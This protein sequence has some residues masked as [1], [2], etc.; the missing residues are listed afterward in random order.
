MVEI[1]DSHPSIMLITEVI[2][3]AQL[4]P[5]EPARLTI[6]G[7]KLYANFNPLDPELGRSGIRGVCIYVTDALQCCEVTFPDS[8]FSEHLWVKI[9]L[10][11][12]DS[13]VLGCIYRSPSSGEES[14]HQFRQLLQLVMAS[15]PSHLLLTGDF[16]LGDIDWQNHLSLAPPSHCSHSFLEVIDDHFLHQH[17][18]F[19]TRFRQG[20]TPGI[21]DLIFTNEEG[22][23][24]NLHSTPGLGKSDHI[25]LKFSLVGYSSQAPSATPKLAL[26]RGN[27]VH[28][29]ELARQVSWTVPNDSSIDTQ[30]KTFQAKLDHICQL[31][32]PY[33]RPEHRRRNIFMTRE[34]MSLKK[35]KRQLWRTYV[36]SRDTLDHARFVRARNDLRWLTRR[37][38]KE[39]EASLVRGMKNDTKPFWRYTNTRLK[40]KSQ[41]EDLVRPDGSTASTDAEK[42]QMLADFFSSVFCHDEDAADVPSLTPNYA[43]TV[44]EDVEITASAVEEKLK[45][46]RP[47]SSPGPDQLHP[48]VLTEL[49]ASL[50]TPLSNLY[51]ESLSRGQLPDDWKVGQVVPI[52]KKGRK[53]EASNY[54]PVSLTSVASK[55]MESIIRDRLLEHLQATDQLTNAQHGFV[56]YRSCATQLLATMEDWTRML[57]AGEPVDVVYTDFRKAFDSVPHRRLLSKLH[58]L[59]IRGRL[60]KWLEAFL[61]GRRQRV[62]VNG[63]FSSWSDVTSG[64]P[65]GSVLGP[66]LFTLYV[67]D[68]PDVVTGAVQLFADD[69]KIYRG[70]RSSVDHDE[71]QRDLDRLARWSETWLLPFNVAKCSTLHLGQGNP[72][73][74]YAIQGMPL[75]QTRVERDLGV[76]VDDQLKFR[77]QAAA[78]ASRANRIL[79]LIRHTFR[80]LDCKTLPILYKTIVRPLLEYG[81]QTWGPFNMADRKLLERVQR[82]ATKLIPEVRHLPYQERLRV[83]ALPS[84]QYRRRRGDMI[85]MF[86]I[87]HGRVRLRKEDFFDKPRAAQ[88]RGHQLKVAKHQ[89][90]SR[91]RCNHFSI[92]VVND[93]NSLPEEVV[94]APSLDSFK[95]R[96]D[97]HWIALAYEAP[98]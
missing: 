18:N 67:N 6:P 31:C 89:S 87:M 98:A 53:D 97:K 1:A 58:S 49:A 50:S 88:T 94:C 84:L 46:L 48:R 60:H 3:K 72:K 93:W 61:T 96:L 83:L 78:A 75:Q 85:L 7:Y 56:P 10:H 17:V 63:T 44:L 69:M 57:E 59:G 39:F 77:E 32:I 4:Q 65:Q 11:G 26:N 80:N 19:P 52:Y 71:L 22:M 64:I 41:V 81:N 9:K 70:I 25:I 34:A 90:T 76:L 55:V 43:G 28:L 33:Q 68:L 45:N 40:T 95:N 82:R 73:R 35:K 29:A 5:I 54:R 8:N 21:L 79:G 42:A 2:P 30:F 37:L 23:V 91:I 12:G 24:Q 38:R 13:L 92:R 51:R 66:V 62:V 36:R 27:Y 16:N 20:N 14:I 47:S 86:N 74:V 15:C